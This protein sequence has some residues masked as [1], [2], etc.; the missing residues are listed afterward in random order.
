MGFPFGSV[1]FMLLLAIGM[2]YGQAQ[3]KKKRAEWGKLLTIVCGILIIITAMWTNLCRSNIDQGAIDREKRYQEVQCMVLATTLSNMYNGNGKCLIIHHPVY[4]NSTREIDRLVEAFKKGFGTKVTEVRAQ[5]IKIISNENEMAEEAML[6]MTAADFNRVMDNNKDCDMVITMVPLPFSEDQLYQIGAFEM[7]P[8]ENDPSIYVKN[9]DRK[10]PLLGVYNG[11]VGN[12]EPLF[13][14]GLIG[15]MTL[16]KPNPTIDEKPVPDAVQ[17]AFDKRYL[18]I[19]PQN[20]DATK[21]THP[22]L[23]PK[24]RK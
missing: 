16:W 7:I 24:P 8:D 17:E 2:F 1:V 12:L 4:G 6:E 10:Y 19:T 13:L 5:P 21:K 23:F 22:T 11:Y 9:P 18:V 15:A 20:I 14:D 3:Y